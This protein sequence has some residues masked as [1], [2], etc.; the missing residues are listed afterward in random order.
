MVRRPTERTGEKDEPD[1]PPNIFVIGLLHDLKNGGYS[2]RAWAAFWRASWIRSVQIYQ[3]NDDLRASWFRFT[4]AGAMAMILVSL[5]VYGYFGLADAVG[6]L[7]TSLIWWV[8]LMFDLALHLGLMV[9]LESGDL[10]PSL[11]WP[12]RL[13]ELRGFSAVW[14]A[15]A[16]H[17]AS[18][19]TYLP[20]VAVFGLAAFTDLADGWLARR[21]HAST[22]W[23]RLYDP[24][25]D[26]I[27]FSVAAISLAV[28]GVLPEWLAALVTFRYALPIVGGLAFLV[29]RRRTLRVRHTPWGRASSAAIAL[30]V[31]GAAAATSLHLPF[32]TIAPAFYGLVGVTAVGAL[33]TILMKGIEQA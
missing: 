19:G 7:T 4:V 15:W 14:V 6:F 17:W 27:F 31:F 12:N 1:L 5:G 18:S 21:R 13:T 29:V 9:N 32:G 25:M 33:I 26:G 16:A 10:Q 3:M 28:I 2:R 22:R 30:T 23:G 24:L 11:G 8:V 20:L